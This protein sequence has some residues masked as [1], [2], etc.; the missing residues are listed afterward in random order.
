MIKYLQVNWQWYRD[1][2]ALNNSST[3]VDFA[4]NKTNN[5]FKFKRKIQVLMV[6]RMLK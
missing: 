5:S 6:Q 2:S 3:V 4:D 1:E